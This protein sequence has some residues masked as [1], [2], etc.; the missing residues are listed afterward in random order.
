MGWN[1]WIYF[2]N[3]DINEHIIK[4]VIDSMAAKGLDTLGYEYIVV[5]GMN[6]RRY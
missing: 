5:D 4:E 1:S 2:G 6:Y 3:N